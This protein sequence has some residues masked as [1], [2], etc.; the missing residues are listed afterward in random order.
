MMAAEIEPV[1]MEKQGECVERGTR[2]QRDRQHPE[3]YRPRHLRGFRF[4]GASLRQTRTRQF[5]D[6]LFRMRTIRRAIVL[7]FVATV[8]CV[9]FANFVVQPSRRYQ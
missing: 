9:S 5:C 8:T 2:Q 7:L 1:R 4:H 3:P 6:K